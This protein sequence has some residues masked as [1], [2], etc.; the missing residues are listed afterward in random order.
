MVRSGTDFQ[1]K[2]AQA[3][4]SSHEKRQM[5]WR[6]EGQ[7]KALLSAIDY[8]ADSVAFALADFAFALVDSAAGSV[9]FAGSAD[10]DCYRYCRY[11]VVPT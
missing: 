1:L 5:N 9:D 8:F 7:N 4:S 10:S 2:K 3:Q 11:L 6:Y